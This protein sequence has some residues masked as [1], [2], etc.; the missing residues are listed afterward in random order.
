MATTPRLPDGET[1]LAAETLDL[2]V[3]HV[4][5]DMVLV[6]GQALAFWMQRF[7]VDS[8][9]ATVTNDGDLLGTAGQLHHLA[10]AL[11]AVA[12]VPGQHA[13]TALVGQVRLP[14]GGG[15]AH[16]I[17]VLH[18]LYT[19]G[20]SR[21]SAEFTRRVSARAVE[22]VWRGRQAIRVMHP[23]DVL[24]SR[25]ENAAG[26]LEEKGPHVL[27]QAIWSIEVARAALLRVA[28][29]EDSGNERIGQLV[30]EVCRLT[31][32]RPGRQLLKDHGIDILDAIDLPA[33]LQACGPDHAEQFRRVEAAR[34]R[35]RIGRT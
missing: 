28:G 11:N 9:Q 1:P 29:A 15:R 23:L 24:A 8:Q 12:L 27:T 13:R 5:A 6:G 33:L 10:D 30:Q 35:R 31:H 16:N 26:L 17:D 32:S 18:Q 2:L 14:A 34:K 7:G 22:M 25:V 4:G 21:K 20:G 19:V 3:T